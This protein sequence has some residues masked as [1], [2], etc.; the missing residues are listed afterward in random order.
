LLSRVV[1]G[2]LLIPVHLLNMKLPRKTGGF[3]EERMSIAQMFFAFFAKQAR[4]TRRGGWIVLAS[5]LLMVATLLVPGMSRANAAEGFI[6]EPQKAFDTIERFRAFAGKTWRPLSIEVQPGEIVLVVEEAPRARPLKR[7]VIQESSFLGLNRITASQPQA[8]QDNGPVR[9]TESALFRFED[10]PLQTLAKI[11]SAA[12][13]RAALEGRARV[14]NVVIRKGISFGETIASGPLRIEIALGSASESAT[15]VAMPDGTIIGADL[16]NTRRARELDLHKKPWPAADAQAALLALF[17]E[18]ELLQE[19]RVYRDYVFVVAEDPQNREKTIDVSWRLGGLTQSIG[20]GLTPNILAL[21]GKRNQ[22]QFRM[23][24]V[25]LTV[26]SAMLDAARKEAGDAAARVTYV[27]ATK[28]MFG[29]K[30]AIEWKIDI[31]YPN[32]EKAK[33]FADAAGKIGRVVLP[34]SRQPVEPQTIGK[35]TAYAIDL[36]RDAFGGGVR[37]EEIR[38][39]SD[40]TLHVMVETDEKQG[41]LQTFL[42]TDGRLQAFGAARPNMMGS[43]NA[44]FGLNDI[45]PKVTAKSLD[46]YCVQVIKYLG[47]NAK[48]CERITIARGGFFDRAQGQAHKAEVGVEFRTLDDTG[49]RWGW[50]TVSIRDGSIMDENRP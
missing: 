15:V 18:R 23:T 20:S 31:T 7:I 32:K 41:L 48:R 1:V 17:G 12:R 38:G 14:T 30:A 37:I 42:I 9:D 50:V 34:A 46:D 39:D 26:V 47:E 22:R 4:H 49:N 45:A 11:A 36:L 8:V 19:I 25:D 29:T 2:P 27:E 44:T 28:L 10:V 40:G 3:Q 35:T 6:E 5:A 33:I 21:G 43:K 16:S 13:D 24:E